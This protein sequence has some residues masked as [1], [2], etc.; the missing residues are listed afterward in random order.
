MTPTLRQVLWSSCLVHGMLACR[1]VSPDTYSLRYATPYPPQ[2]PF[3]RA[4]K[5]WVAHVE[6]ASHGRLRIE[7]HGSG[8]LLSSDQS[9]IEL[10]HGVADVGAIQPI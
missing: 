4:D 10:R 1:E 9:L 5:I 3:S 8:S 7:A 2:H 6:A